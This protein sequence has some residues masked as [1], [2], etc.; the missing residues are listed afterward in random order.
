MPCK[1]RDHSWERN[2]CRVLSSSLL[3]EFRQG[4]AGSASRK[5]ALT[6]KK[7]T[8]HTLQQKSPN[9]LAQYYLVEGVWY[10]PNRCCRNLIKQQ[11]RHENW[12][13][14]IQKTKSG[15]HPSV[16]IHL[17][18]SGPTSRILYVGCRARERDAGR[19]AGRHTRISLF[20]GL[21]SGGL[22]FRA[23]GLGFSGLGCWGLGLGL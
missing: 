4:C 15:E 21:G 1:H 20:W 14:T 17:A 9:A 22:G 23:E 18:D 6:T 12:N 2:I 13:E 16:A 8:L 5:P 10:L 3:H 11:L 7:Q 19:E